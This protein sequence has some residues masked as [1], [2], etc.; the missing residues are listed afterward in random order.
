MI[1]EGRQRAAEGGGPY[2]YS[3]GAGPLTGPFAGNLDP[4]DRRCS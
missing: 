2:G 1:F 3:A 4:W